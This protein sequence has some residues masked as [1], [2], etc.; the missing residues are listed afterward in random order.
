LHDRRQ[1]RD[2]L[3]ARLTRKQVRFKG[4]ALLRGQGIEEVCSDGI[5]R[6]ALTRRRHRIRRLVG[7]LTAA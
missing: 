7:T 1:Q 3:A 6:F 2:F 4:N 5:V